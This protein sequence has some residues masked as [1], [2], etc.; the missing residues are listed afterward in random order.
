MTTEGRSIS[1]I[2]LSKAMN[3]EM[4]KI[5][6]DP[7]IENNCAIFICTSTPPVNEPGRVHGIFQVVSSDGPPR[8]LGGVLGFFCLCGRET[9]SP[10]E[11]DF[12]FGRRKMD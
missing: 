9:S 3:T 2:G 8:I 4:I 12:D 1:T 11:R 7:T 6:I 10:P 5:A